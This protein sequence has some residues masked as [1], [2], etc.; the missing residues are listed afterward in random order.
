M[1]IELLGPSGIGKSTVLNAV[2]ANKAPRSK[3]RGILN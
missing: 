2:K 1:R 3:L